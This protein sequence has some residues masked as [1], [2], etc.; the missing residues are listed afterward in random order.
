MET[1]KISPLDT[2]SRQTSK[3]AAKMG[4][5]PKYLYSSEDEGTIDLLATIEE[6]V[7]KGDSFS[8]FIDQF[9]RKNKNVFRNKDLLEIWISLQPDI[10]V[11]DDLIKDAKN[12][13]F[14]TGLSVRHYFNGRKKF[15]SDLDDK[16]Q[17]NIKK[18]QRFLKEDEDFEMLRPSGAKYGP[19]KQTSSDYSIPIKN[20]KNLNLFTLF[21]N[22][23]LSDETP[24]ATYND[25]FKIM[26]GFTPDE[27]MI[28]PKQKLV[29]KVIDTK[30]GVIP[31]SYNNVEID[32][33]LDIHIALKKEKNLVDGKDLEKR[34]VKN[35][36]LNLDRKKRKE[37]MVKGLFY[38]ANIEF[39]QYLL[40]HMIM[41]DTIFSSFM[42]IDESIKAT[43]STSGLYVK[44]LCLLTGPITADISSRTSEKSA[45]SRTSDVL[46]LPEGTKYIRVRF[47]AKSIEAIDVFK[48]IF[49]KLLQLYKENEEELLAFYRQYLP[50]FG[51][52]DERKGVN[53]EKKK[54]ESELLHTSNY[55]RSCPNKP[56][57]IEED[58]VQ[59]LKLNDKKWQYGESEGKMVAK[60]SKD[61][62]P[63]EHHWFSCAHHPNKP[64]VGLTKNTLENRKTYPYLLCCYKNK[65]EKDG[66]PN[67]YYFGEERDERVKE[68]GVV[69]YGSTR[70]IKS[71]SH[72]YTILNSIAPDK[73]FV[74]IGVD[75][76][77]NSFISCVLNA[78]G[79]EYSENI[80]LIEQGDSLAERYDK[81]KSIRHKILSPQGY[82]TKQSLYDNSI[83][84]IKNYLLSK[85]YADPKFLINLLEVT[86]NCNIFVFSGSK[87]YVTMSIPRH[88]GMYLRSSDFAY[89]D[90]IM[91]YE[92]TDLSDYPHCELIVTNKKSIFDSV[93]NLSNS[94]E[95]IFSE[96]TSYHT[97]KGQV[98]P[99][100]VQ[101]EADVADITFNASGKVNSIFLNLNG[102]LLQIETDPLPVMKVVEPERPIK[103]TP[104]KMREIDGLIELMKIK[105]VIVYASRGN[106]VY[107]TGVM[108]PKN[109]NVKVKLKGSVKGKYSFPIRE[110]EE[111][112]NIFGLQIYR[113][114]KRMARY[115]TSY[116]FYLY[117]QREDRSIAS[118]VNDMIIIDPKHKYDENVGISFTQD[119]T[120]IRGGRLVLQN[121]ET[122][123]R[124]TY[125]LSLQMTHSAEYVMS[126]KDRNLLPNYYNDVSDFTENDNQVI[127]HG[128]RSMKKWINSVNSSRKLTKSV[129]AYVTEPYFFQNKI[130]SNRIYLA[131]NASSLQSAIEVARVWNVKHYNIG[132]QTKNKVNLRFTM[133][134]YTD[135]NTITKMPGKNGDIEILGYRV[136]G[137]PQYTVLLPL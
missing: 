124:L 61:G 133:W 68:K 67:N 131:Q 25:F 15:M 71:G 132:V 112:K 11:T 101:H 40:Q 3:V 59:R 47:E 127:L 115:L 43:K 53:I 89:R 108:G 81:V 19:I 73:K 42:Y 39:N 37:T 118:F 7:N 99:V 65:Y 51:E 32:D 128:K 116:F 8:E 91:I 104:L 38:I 31:S 5:I 105:T 122:L 134:L 12:H 103:R 23:K 64:H 50:N 57:V 58:E 94:L 46:D 135:A 120:L 82:L 9:S 111:Q 113:I 21:N 54:I 121:Q 110:I 66:I 137:Y 55:S 77:E 97:L 24:F 75:R 17:E 126:Y 83:Q 29:M 60:Y 13:A 1:E 72:L 114:N 109:M 26:K 125:V 20:K 33:S 48:I 30:K 74:R 79:S 129:N 16:K 44:I 69:R 18:V 63:G 102:R 87:N 41:N 28:W 62:E 10:K 119:S 117:S 85:E 123:D 35:T 56:K 2:P 4:T 92:N 90:T 95:K 45:H 130:I 100:Y 84:Q 34:I 6:S 93:D 27:D 96:M 49:D 52:E 22:L 88:T 78:V 106:G 107:L 70:K 98:N 14:V 80:S 136:D 86:F 76:D 36:G